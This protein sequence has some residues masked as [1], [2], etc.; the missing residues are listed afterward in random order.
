MT[1]LLTLALVLVVTGCADDAPGDAPADV[2]APVP[3][4]PEEV[5]EALVSPIGDGTV[6]GRVTFVSLDDALEIRYD[7]DGLGAGPHGFHVHQVG[8]CGPDSTGT[9]GGAAGGHFNP[10]ESPHGAPSAKPGSRHAGDLGN[11]TTDPEGRASGVVVDS[12][13]SLRGPTSV[14]G[15]ALVVHAGEDDLTSQPSGDA[16]ARIGCGVIRAAPAAADPAA[17]TLA[18]DTVATDI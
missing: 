6:S 15:R 17:D 2:P 1:R 3:A 10:L 12:V 14:L 8:D 16:G 5:I 11:I 18:V 9:P 4:D 7:L 13:L